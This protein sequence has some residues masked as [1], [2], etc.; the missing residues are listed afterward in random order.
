MDTGDRHGQG[1]SA[2]FKASEEFEIAFIC[3]CVFPT[4]WCYLDSVV[5]RA[6]SGQGVKAVIIVAL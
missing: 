2:K 3:I 1:K 5:G 4:G 6:A